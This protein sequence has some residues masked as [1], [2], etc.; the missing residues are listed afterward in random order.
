MPKCYD[1]PPRCVMQ[2][3]FGFCV[4]WFNYQVNDGFIDNKINKKNYYSYDAKDFKRFK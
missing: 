1:K 3:S 2:G 4:D